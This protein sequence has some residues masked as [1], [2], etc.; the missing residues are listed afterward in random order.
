LTGL[1]PQYWAPFPRLV[2]NISPTIMSN[3]VGFIFVYRI[4]FD[5]ETDGREKIRILFDVEKDGREKI[6]EWAWSYFE[7]WVK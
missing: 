3:P 7:P 4:L 6:R 5:V 2:S 1:G